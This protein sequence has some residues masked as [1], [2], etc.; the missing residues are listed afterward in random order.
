ME[1][2]WAPWRSV[3]IGGEHGDDCIF[4][5]SLNLKRTRTISFCFAVK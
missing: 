2:I 3:Y 5:R 1:Q 4:A